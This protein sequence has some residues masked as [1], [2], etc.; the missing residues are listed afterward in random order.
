MN[1]SALIVLAAILSLTLQALDGQ[2][3]ARKPDVLHEL[4]DTLEALTAK[5]SR[6]VVQV[7]ATGYS[8]NEESD[9]ENAALFSKQRS[10]GSAVIFTPDGYLIT[11]NHV[12]QGAQRVRVQ[13]SYA[14]DSGPGGHSIVRRHGKLIPARVVGTDRESDVA[15]LKIDGGPYPALE[16]GNSDALRQGSLVLAFGNPLGLESSVT[17]GVVSSVGRQLRPD[18]PM[19][20]I[21]TDAPINPG[22][23]GG[24][25]LDP[26]GHVVGINT[27][28]L[29]Q[30]GGSEGIGF[31]I[32]SNIV[33]MSPS[34]SRRRDMCIAENRRLRAEHHAGT[35]GRLG[36]AARL[37]RDLWRMSI[38]TVRLRRPD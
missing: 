27:F 36:P 10:S 4:N 6:S 32:P 2:S 14:D 8:F 34:K 5:V 26:D 21:Q 28:I 19:I 38:P 11:N 35:G 25:L 33:K 3:G 20:Y 23:S 24:P 15:V 31:A 30:S 18:D 37:W 17:M 22:N 13:L 29:S 1:Q 9:G 12:V 7:F 16:F